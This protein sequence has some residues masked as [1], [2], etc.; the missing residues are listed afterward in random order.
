MWL[1]VP[2][3]YCPSAPETEDS[4]SAVKIAHQT[5]VIEAKLRT[6][7]ELAA[8]MMAADTLIRDGLPVDLSSFQDRLDAISMDL[9]HPVFHVVRG[10]GDSQV[11][12][13]G[14]I[15][16]C[17]GPGCGASCT[18]ACH[19]FDAGTP[20]SSGISATRAEISAVSK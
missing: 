12:I 14:H 7:P 17:A 8:E 4:T 18:C 16:D 5:G 6:D 3:E 2:R 15:Q 9:P 1:Y 19:A 10:V 13:D 20:V 11:D